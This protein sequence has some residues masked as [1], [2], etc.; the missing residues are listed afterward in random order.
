[1]IRR[2]LIEGRMDP[3]LRLPSDAVRVCIK[4]LND[5]MARRAQRHLCL[6]RHRPQRAPASIFRG[7]TGYAGLRDAVQP[8][9]APNVRR[10]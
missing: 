2:R 6:D 9:A 4:A 5:T 10:G 7:C 8:N 3:A 1:M